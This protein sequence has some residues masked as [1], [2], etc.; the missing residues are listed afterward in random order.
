MEIPGCETPSP[1]NYATAVALSGVFG[2]VGVQHF[3]LRRWWEGLF[4]VGLTIGWMWGFLTG[5]VIWG[6]VFLVIDSAHALYVTIA[7]LTGNF[8]DGS[9]RLVCYPG[10]KLKT[11]NGRCDPWKQ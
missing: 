6:V 5:H 1:R 10:Q 11:I 4:D 9:G 7:L 2:F 3:Y 8:R